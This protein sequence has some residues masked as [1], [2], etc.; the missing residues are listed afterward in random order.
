M[1]VGNRNIPLANNPLAYY[2]HW[3][4]NK[5]RFQKYLAYYTLL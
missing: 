5:K 1:E 3:V 4:E 2:K